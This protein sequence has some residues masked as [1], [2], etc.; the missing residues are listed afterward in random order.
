MFNVTVYGC[1]VKKVMFGTSKISRGIRIAQSLH[2]R[3]LDETED[4]HAIPSQRD[5]YLVPPR[6]TAQ[7]GNEASGITFRDAIIHATL[8]D[9]E[10]PYGAAGLEKNIEVYESYDFEHSPEQKDPDAKIVADDESVSVE[11][12]HLWLS[13]RSA[14]AQ[15]GGRAQSKKRKHRRRRSGRRIGSVG[16]RSSASARRRTRRSRARKQSRSR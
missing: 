2:L 7:F 4:A 11:G 1:V 9:P 12:M 13:Y 5:F 10:F 15:P 16:R 8:N 3:L 14:R 6:W